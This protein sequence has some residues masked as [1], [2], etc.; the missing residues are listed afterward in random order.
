MRSAEAFFQVY[1]R[2]LGDGLPPLLIKKETYLS[3]NGTPIWASYPYRYAGTLVLV[4]RYDQ[5]Q[6]D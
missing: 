4:R 2:L 5:V 3:H 6:V 1:L